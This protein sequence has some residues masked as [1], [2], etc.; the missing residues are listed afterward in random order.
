MQSFTRQLLS[1]TKGFPDCWFMDINFSLVGVGGNT[2]HTEY[3][4]HKYVKVINN[5][6]LWTSFINNS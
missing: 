2:N 4:I 3:T 1:W 5:S 6:Y